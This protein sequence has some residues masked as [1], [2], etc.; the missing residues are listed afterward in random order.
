[1]LSTKNL[2]NTG[3]QVSRFSLLFGT[4]LLL[5]FF[6]TDNNDLLVALV[7]VPLILVMGLCNLKLLV[8]L[9]WRGYQEQESRKALWRAG[10]LMSLNIPAALLYAKLVLVRL[11]NTTNQPL[12]HVVVVG[13]GEQR[14]LADLPPGQAT[15]LWLPISTACFERTVSV[16]YSTGSTTQQAIIDGYVVEGRR[17][18]MKL[19]SDQQVAVTKR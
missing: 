7:S 16:Q 1:M 6:F 19:G 15:I 5:L 2:I 8:Q 18:N 3:L 4:A 10:A 11:V 9:V 14:P 13:C 12:Q 17:I